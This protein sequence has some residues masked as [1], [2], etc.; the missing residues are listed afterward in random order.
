MRDY[1]LD[2]VSKRAERRPLGQGRASHG[3]RHLR[4]HC[5]TKRRAGH[6]Q[7]TGV[8]QKLATGWES[9][10]HCQHTM[11]SGMRA[12]GTLLDTGGAALLTAQQSVDAALEIL[13]LRLLQSAEACLL[14]AGL[15]KLP[16][17]AVTHHQH[18]VGLGILGITL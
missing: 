1:I 8:A 2:P 12:P 15:C 9:T 13:R 4:S 18:V 14:R 11:A 6:Q 3:R 10:R 16:P 7:C 17:F 5:R